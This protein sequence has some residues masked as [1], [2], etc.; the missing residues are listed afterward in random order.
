M[1]QLEELRRLLPHWIEHNGECAQEFER[2]AP[3]IGEITNELLA[4]AR[5]LEDARVPL[6]AA[7]DKLG[8]PLGRACS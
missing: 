6:A 3:R 7:L 1:D 4:A 2:Y 5:A 8:G